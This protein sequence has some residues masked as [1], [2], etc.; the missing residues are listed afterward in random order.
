VDV[1]TALDWLL[2]LFG[3][4]TQAARIRFIIGPV[5]LKAAPQGDEMLILTDEQKVALSI[6]PVTA[7]GNPAK[8]DGV[9][10]WSVS[11]PSIL[12]LIVA[13]DGLSAEAVTAGPLGPC[14]V[15]VSCDADLGAGVRTISGTLDVTV[16]AA[17]AVSVGIAAGAP[18]TK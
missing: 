5:S 4:P 1:L 7:A 11:D 2:N 16:Q 8:V 9:P 3:R 12:A 6:Q 15:S 13:D 17:E 10:T 14:Q 18:E